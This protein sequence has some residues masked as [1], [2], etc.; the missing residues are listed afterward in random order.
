MYKELPITTRVTYDATVAALGKLLRPPEQI[1]LKKIEF[2][3]R[4]RQP[5]ESLASLARVLRQ[6]AHQ[7]YPTLEEAA[8]LS[9]AKDQFIVSLEPPDFRLHVRMSRPSTLEEA[10]SVAMEIES[11][12]KVEESQ[13]N[14]RPSRVVNAAGAACQALCESQVCAAISPDRQ[15]TLEKMIA[16]NTATLQGVIESLKTISMSMATGAPRGRQYQLNVGCWKC[17]QRGHIRRNCPQGDDDRPTG[18]EHTQGNG[19]G[20]THR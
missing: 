18:G 13:A 15:G 17:G 20:P 12:L 4:R 14:Q 6:L 10:V 7:A 9:L 8:R 19:R 16:T 3:S 1:E 5:G 11:A 2:Q